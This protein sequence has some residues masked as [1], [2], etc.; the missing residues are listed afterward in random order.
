MKDSAFIEKDKLI[1][2]ISLLKL[3]KLPKKNNR[4]NVGINKP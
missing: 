4:E 2:E 3:L 1:R